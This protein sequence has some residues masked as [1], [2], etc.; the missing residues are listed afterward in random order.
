ME[1]HRSLDLGIVGE[2][3]RVLHWALSII[4]IEIDDRERRDRRFGESTCTGVKSVQ[5]M[6]GIPPTGKID[7]APL[8]S[9]LGALERIRA[10]TRPR[11]AHNHVRKL[12]L[13][14]LVLMFW[15][16][17]VPSL[18]VW[19]QFISS[20]IQP[21][22]AMA[23]FAAMGGLAGGLAR[24]LFF[25]AV[26]SY[27]FNHKLRTHKS[28]KWALSVSPDLDDDFD[29]LWVWY[30]WCLEPLVGA[31]VGLVFALAVGI[32]LVSLGTTSTPT[33]DGNIRLLVLG[34]LAGFFFEGAFERIRRMFNAP[35][36]TP[37]G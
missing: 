12:C 27:A 11:Q 9:V 8:A 25:F 26:D 22:A 15:C 23:V 18:L 28:S 1:T 37:G 19:P 4:G 31:A 24:S 32:G 34:G 5:T 13:T 6:L 20:R 35:S 21:P 16:A 29:P 2:D 33:W 3:V 36:S 14:C 10:G 7:D 17:M 30:L